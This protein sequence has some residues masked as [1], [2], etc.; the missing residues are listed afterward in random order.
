MQGK[1]TADIFKVLYQLSNQ[2]NSSLDFEQVLNS[3]MARVIDLMSAERGF[4]M[5][6]QGDQLECHVSHGI[7]RESVKGG[8]DYSRSI[9]DL[10]LA[11]ER[12]MRLTDALTDES[13]APKASIK[14]MGVRSVLCVPL[15]VKDRAIGIIYLD[16][17]KMSAAF[18]PQDL[19]I[20]VA[21]ANNAAIAIENARLYKDLRE[22]IEQR[23]ALERKVVEQEKKTAILETS[24]AM[25]EEIAH[26]LVHD[27]RNPLGVVISNLS[28]LK[29]TAMNAFDKDEVEAFEETSQS[30]DKLVGMVNSIL[31][32]YRMEEGEVTLNSTAFD[33]GSMVEELARTNRRIV[34]SEVA[35]VA[36]VQGAPLQLHAD[37]DMIRRVL[38]NLISNA[39]YFTTQGSISLCASRTHAGT[40][41]SVSDTGVGIPEEYTKKIFEK[42][43]RVETR[44]GRLKGVFGLGLRFCQLA[45]DAHRGRIWVES[46][47]GKGSTFFV[48]LP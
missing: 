41:I 23:V 6:R 26:Y 2:L 25:R 18:Q 16:T 15:I 21:F 10:V 31:E 13:I 1:D 28:Y 20:L 34:S 12:P 36:Q 42:F 30:A 32:I 48:Q 38:S 4:I 29:P 24:Q 8:K 47:V 11:Q 44:V 7:P 19:D 35:L 40:L 17:T 46:E 33:V 9:V 5:L 37:K 45:V 39:A 27:L 3:A 22:N 14:M 43:G